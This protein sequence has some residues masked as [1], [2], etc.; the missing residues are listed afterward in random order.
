MVTLGTPSGA[1][2]NPLPPLVRVAWALDGRGVAAP[3]LFSCTVKLRGASS[4][5]DPSS[6]SA[7]LPVI[8]P[9]PWGP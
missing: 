5:E 7:I 2:L 1:A 3:A 6:S 9:G 8:E 4:S